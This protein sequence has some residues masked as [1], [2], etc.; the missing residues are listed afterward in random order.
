MKRYCILI[1]LS[2]F[3]IF[4]LA[5]KP[6]QSQTVPQKIKV[7]VNLASENESHKSLMLSYIKRE[8]RSLHDVEIVDYK[9]SNATWDYC[10]S[11]VMFQ[12]EYAD[13]RKLDAVAMAKAY[14]KRIPISRIN[15]LWS[16]LYKKWAVVDEPNLSVKVTP[17]DKLDVEC[18]TIV[19]KFDTDYLESTRKLRKLR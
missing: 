6:I 14:L 8:L 18:K 19:A 15:G 5:G 17:I 7:S 13:G 12:I 11:I 10:I 16:D 2:M 4:C 1:L 9:P 3:S